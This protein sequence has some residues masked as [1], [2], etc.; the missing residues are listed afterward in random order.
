MGSACQEGG[1]INESN[2]KHT[3]K[4]MNATNVSTHR[5]GDRAPTQPSNLPLFAPFGILV[6]R[7]WQL[8]ACLLLVC[9][10]AFAATALR[11]QR[12]QAVARVEVVMDQI[13]GIVS[14]VGGDYFSTQYQ[15]LKSRH[16]LA[17]AVNK[18][19]VLQDQWIIPTA[20]FDPLEYLRESVDVQPVPGSRLIDI[21]GVSELP[22]RAAA[23]AN[24]VTSAF[25]ETSA[26]ARQAA[27]QR[28]IS[29]V[30]EQIRIY[31]ITIQEKEAAVNKFRQE[32]LITGSDTGLAAIEARIGSIETKLTLAQMQRLELE[33]KRTRIH[34]MLKSGQG[35]GDHE[36]TLTEISQNN[37]TISLKSK[38]STLSESE[39][40]LARVYLSS[41]PRLRDVR[42]Q[43]AQLQTRLLDQKHNLM[44]QLLESTTEQ[45]TAVVKQEQALLNL[46][47][48]QKETGVKLTD[49]HQRYQ[50]LLAEWESAKKFKSACE[51]HVRD[52]TLQEGIA[53]SPVVVVDAAHIP[54]KPMGLDKGQQAASILLLGILFS[55]AFIFAL[56]RISTGSAES[57]NVPAPFAAA[58][59]N[60][61]QMAP[62][63]PF[64]WAAPVSTQQQPESPV[65]PEPEPQRNAGSSYVAQ[66]DNITIAGKADSDLAFATR[67]RIVHVDQPCSA[68]ATFREIASHLITR[69]KNTKHSVVV[70][71]SQTQQG[72]TTCAFNLAIALAK[73]S[74]KVLLVE[75][76]L[77]NPALH[78]AL[79]KENEKPTFFDVVNDPSLLDQSVCDPDIP[80][81]TILPAGQNP[82]ST[83]PDTDSLEQFASQLKDRFDWILYDS[84][85]LDEPLTRQLLQIVGKCLYV[86]TSSDNNTSTQ[87]TEFIES[88]GALNIASI[89]NSQTVPSQVDQLKQAHS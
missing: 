49:Q 18:L 34:A 57:E 5:P 8:L 76:N 79:A 63:V 41:H 6:R 16:V 12:Y 89:K 56:D 82:P 72:T 1:F 86:T 84:G 20:D 46:L 75:A 21:I 30:N 35:L 66:I 52:F 28:I 55:L 13:S 27:N 26:E 47:I 87:A 78:R 53:E 37:E 19:S 60:I 62:G 15:L 73:A 45:Y 68:A 36:I 85:T 10:V 61:S 88:C 50:A 40:A 71:G 83:E 29:K 54:T 11:K 51:A 43:I 24:Q 14:N 44:R 38:I 64:Y 65:Q 69:F 23:I 33:A 4:I 59:V 22:E 80:Q 58:P 17:R 48:K 31:E 42:V 81:L 7:R 77:K 70:S 25:I 32:N 74:R 39:S 3:G 67:C 2:I 9:G